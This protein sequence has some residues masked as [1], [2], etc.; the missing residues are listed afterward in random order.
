[1]S[2][3]ICSECAKEVFPEDQFCRGCGKVLP[4][5][6]QDQTGP[7]VG[8]ADA[9]HLQPESISG[10]STPHVASETPRFLAGTIV[11]GRY[12]IIAALGRGGMGEV[13]RADDLTLGQSVAL[14]F[15]PSALSSD[16]NWL[17]RLRT[18]V[19]IARQVS[20][21]HVCR[22]YDIGEAEGHVFLSME[23]ID[24]EDLSSLLKK[25]GRLPEER[26]AMLARQ[27]CMGLAAA[28]EKGIIHRDL[29]PHN[30]ML[31]SRGQVR[32]TDFGLAGFLAEIPGTDLR[33][34]TP[35]YM[36]P[37]QLA[38]KGVSVHSDLF[39]LG[40]ILYELFTG[41]RPF[42]ARNTQ[43][44]ARLYQE[45]TPSKPSSDGLMLA[46]AIENIIFRCLQHEPQNRLASALAV[47]ACLPGGDPL[48]EALA[49]GETPSPE[50]VAD[51]P[52]FVGYF[53]RGFPHRR[54]PRQ[55]NAAHSQTV[56][57]PFAAGACFSGAKP[58]AEVRFQPAGGGRSRKVLY[59][60]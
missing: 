34:G 33:V 20:H 58:T 46:P 21:P 28:H 56:L 55:S 22:V 38:G 10:S 8:A 4:K 27:I 53:P 6:P 44:L 39:A 15:L 19:R 2:K 16:P 30:V 31:D 32:I 9:V 42:K 35:A 29:K 51:A 45:N 48:R 41:K 7:Y 40:L 1:M 36:A 26:G 17:A 23:F 3:I 57:R 25:V 59:R 13:Y 47:L 18:E 5:Q 52:C 49:A 24:G 60:L 14:K 43:E 54:P 37:E 12:R 11:A 50:Q